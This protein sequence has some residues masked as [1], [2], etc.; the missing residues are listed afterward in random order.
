MSQ[1]DEYC[2]NH[3]CNQ[4]PGCAARSSPIKQP[5]RRDEP[6]ALAADHAASGW[7]VQRLPS[8]DTEGGEA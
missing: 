2:D 4:G 1:C 3:G 6:T 8:D 7:P 5:A